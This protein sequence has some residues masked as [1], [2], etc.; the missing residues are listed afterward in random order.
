MLFGDMQYSVTH[1]A[2][3]LGIKNGSEV[4]YTLTRPLE[5]KSELENCEYLH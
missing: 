5:S 4:A 2:T 1:Q 3:V